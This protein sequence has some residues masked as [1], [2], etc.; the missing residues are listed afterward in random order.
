MSFLDH[1]TD[2]QFIKPEHRSVLLIDESSEAL[3]DRI[4]AYQL[5]KVDKAAWIL[6][7]TRR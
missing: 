6:E 1:A 4:A 7:M 3:L 2:E 5:S